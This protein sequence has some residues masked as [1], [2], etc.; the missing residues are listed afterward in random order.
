MLHDLPSHVQTVAHRIVGRLEG[1]VML[2]N[3]SDIIFCGKLLWS[4][5]NICSFVL[6]A[7]QQEVQ[8]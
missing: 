8:A 4:R 7:D 6:P 1:A 2:D 3:V 5:G